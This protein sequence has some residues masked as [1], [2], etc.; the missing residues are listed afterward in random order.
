MGEIENK[1]RIGKE[2]ISQK[3]FVDVPEVMTLNSSSFGRLKVIGEGFD[4]VIVNYVSD[5]KKKTINKT[6]GLTDSV[7]N[8]FDVKK[9]EN[10]IEL[11]R[12]GLMTLEF[13]VKNKIIKIKKIRFLGGD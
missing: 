3:K 5:N 1:K 4:Q 9:F 10:E 13:K 8:K 6:Y 11:Y 2:V 7:I 12:P